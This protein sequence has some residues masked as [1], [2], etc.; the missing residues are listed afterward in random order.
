MLRSVSFLSS[1]ELFEAGLLLRKLLLAQTC[2]LLEAEF[3]REGIH[4]LEE[5]L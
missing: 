3:E 5:V 4:M 2:K 1:L